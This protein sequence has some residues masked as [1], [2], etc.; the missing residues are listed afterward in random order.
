MS[1]PTVLLNDGNEDVTELVE[2]ALEAGF[3]HI[4]SAAYYAN[5]Q[6]IGTAIRESGLGRD[7]IFMAT[8]YDGGDVLEA[9]QISLDKLGLK[10]LDLYLIHNPRVIRDGD[11]EGTWGEM[12]KVK[13]AGLARSIGVSNFDL[14]QLQRIVKMGKTIPAVN[15]IQLNPYNYAWWKDTLEFSEKHGIVTAIFSSLAPITTYPDGPLDRV[16]AAAAKR[17][18]GT[19]VQVI[20]KWAH[21]KGFVVV[22]TTSQR[23]RMQEYLDTA[24]LQDLT[25]EEID[26]IDVA[27]AKGPP[28]Q[29]VVRPRVRVAG[30]LA[31]LLLVMV[32]RYLGWFSLQFLG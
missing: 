18:G 25:I 11:I 17:I 15:Q 14:E 23:T 10:H 26:A 22:T 30:V 19:P 1:V 24:D 31:L 9:A 3:S 2:Q 28:T 7:E 20:F 8:K 32:L 5:E 12:I 29:L 4:D 21:A 6:Y 16:L 27:G 13:E